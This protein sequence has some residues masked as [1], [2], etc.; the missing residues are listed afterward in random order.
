MLVGVVKEPSVFRSKCMLNLV[1]PV[2][3][4]HG[5]L[6]NS[7]EPGF[8]QGPGF[9]HSLVPIPAGVAQVIE[10]QRSGGTC[11]GPANRKWWPMVE[12]DTTNKPTQAQKLR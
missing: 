2:E 6:A 7:K 9:H 3:G 4:Y 10:E 1:D 11:I 8:G 12:K 5:L